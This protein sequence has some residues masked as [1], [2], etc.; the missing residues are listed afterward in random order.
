MAGNAAHVAR[1]DAP[2]G[3]ACTHIAAGCEARPEIG[4]RTLP[5]PS[6]CRL[7]RRTCLARRTHPQGLA[8]RPGSSD[9]SPGRQRPVQTP[10]WL[11]QS[12]AGHAPDF[13]ACALAPSPKPPPTAKRPASRGQGPTQR[14]Q[15]PSGW[16]VAVRVG[17]ASLQ[18]LQVVGAALFPLLTTLDDAM[19][20][21][22]TPGC[23]HH[24]IA[25]PLQ[26]AQAPHSTLS[27]PAAGFP[28]ALPS[29]PV[30][31][32]QWSPRLNR[33]PT[34]QTLSA[35]PRARPPLLWA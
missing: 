24:A 7:P 21:S 10:P 13:S 19:V 11:K 3:L 17:E 29:I 33:L 26:V 2:W 9:A 32:V 6:A 35:T 15:R 1:G 30:L 8:G 34:R 22:R 18:A 5:A 20:A 14:E 4:L 12:R 27:K 25:S 23:L 28:L 31:P 16:L